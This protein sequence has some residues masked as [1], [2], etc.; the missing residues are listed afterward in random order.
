MLQ[1]LARERGAP[2]RASDQKSARAAVAG[3]PHEIADPLEAEH[4]VVDVE[5][6]HADAVIRIGGRGR[7][8]GAQAPRLVDA[9]LENLPLLVLAIEHELI[10]VLRRVE[11]AHRG[12][13]ADLAEHAFHA[14]GARLVGND[15]H[16]VLADVL[17]PDQRGEDPHQ[18]HGGGDL[19]VLRSLEQR[20]EGLER[21]HLAAAAPP[22]C[23]RADSR[24]A[25]RGAPAGSAS[26]RCRAPACGT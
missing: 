8:P 16:D 13:D 26:P 22:S 7:D 6:H 12:I 10:G 2:G 25:P 19:A 23:A 4:R 21:R 24:R 5:R 15:R 9:L 18:R 14:E 17:V 1:P 20:A 11:L 3:G